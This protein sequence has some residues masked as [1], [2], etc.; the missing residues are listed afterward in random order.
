MEIDLFI[1]A[2]SAGAMGGCIA[3]LTFYWHWKSLL[4]DYLEARQNFKGMLKL[5]HIQD[6]LE[7]MRLELNVIN[8]EIYEQS[9]KM[10]KCYE[11]K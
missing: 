4:R 6:E 7:K 2:V 5:H 9:T 1:I 8:L 3:L 10:C 11:K